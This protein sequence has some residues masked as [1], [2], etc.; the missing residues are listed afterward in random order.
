MV[1]QQ[2][3]FCFQNY[4]SRSDLIMDSV[5]SEDNR[6][7]LQNYRSY[8]LFFLEAGECC[9]KVFSWFSWYQKDSTCLA[10]CRNVAGSSRR[11]H[12]WLGCPFSCGGRCPGPLGCVPASVLCMVPGFSKVG[13]LCSCQ[14]S[15]EPVRGHGFLSLSTWSRYA[16]FSTEK[17][18]GS[19]FNTQWLP[20]LAT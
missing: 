2:R 20:T 18:R 6:A 1:I 10:Y 11:Q 17:A 14:P 15:Q 13:I 12:M 16:P 9:R 19:P 5:K 8:G 4:L 3:L 7:S